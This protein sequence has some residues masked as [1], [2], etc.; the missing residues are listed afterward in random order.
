MS[1]KV[2]LVGLLLVTAACMS[3]YAVKSNNGAAEAPKV[4]ANPGNDTAKQ[5]KA[6]KAPPAEVE[7]WCNAA[8]LIFIGKVVS[9]GKPPASWCQFGI[10]YQ[11][12]TQKVVYKIETALKGKNDE[13]AVEVFFLITHG[14]PLCDSEPRLNAGI[15]ATG[16]RHLVFAQQAMNLCGDV[17][18]G[19][20][21]TKPAVI[22]GI[23]AVEPTDNL[24]SD[25]KMA[26]EK[27]GK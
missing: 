12:S 5:W 1:R 6:V 19:E 15:F 8:P 25:V 13:T 9:V 20:H 11:L 4:S 10:I 21:A 18:D 16:N 26:L 27:Q 22:R 7:S 24:V 2:F 17:N 3:W 23:N 14:N